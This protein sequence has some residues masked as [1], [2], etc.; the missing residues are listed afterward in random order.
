MSCHVAQ[1][2]HPGWTEDTLSWG[3]CADVLPQLYW[4]SVDSGFRGWFGLPLLS[5]SFAV[6]APSL[7]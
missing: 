1:M 7:C 5:C 3:F 4:L 6:T 2:T